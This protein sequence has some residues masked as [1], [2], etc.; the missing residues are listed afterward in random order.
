[1]YLGFLNFSD[2]GESAR[3]DLNICNVCLYSYNLL[4]WKDVKQPEKKKAQGKV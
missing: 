4:H 2:F 3:R 1:M